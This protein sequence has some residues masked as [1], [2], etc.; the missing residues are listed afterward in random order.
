MKSYHLKRGSDGKGLAADI[1]P[2]S[3]GWN[4]AKRFWM[5]LGWACHTHEVGWGGVFDLPVSRQQTLL[6]AMK[7]LSEKG[8]PHGADP[9]YEASI[10]WDPAHCQKAFNWKV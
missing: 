5:L 3:T 6:A 8:W 4:A 10:G 7:R 2:R 9:D 1:V